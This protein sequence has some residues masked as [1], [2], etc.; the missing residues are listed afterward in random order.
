MACQVQLFG[1]LQVA[2]ANG[3]VT[4]KG[5]KAQGLL[6]FLLL[7]PRVPYPREALAERLWPDA[8][9]A[10]SRRNLSDLLYRLK[11]VLGDAWFLLEPETVALNP[12]L[13]LSVDVWEFEHCIADGSPAALTQAVDLYTGD[14][15]PELYD[16]WL[17]PRR[18]ALR[19]QWLDALAQLGEHAERNQQFEPALT[20]YRRLI[21]ADPLREE[22]WRG[23]MRC[24]ARLGRHATALQHYAQLR[25]VL[26]AELSVPPSA[27]TFM[28]AERL[29]SESLLTQPDDDVDRLTHPPFTGRRQ[30]RAQCLAA[31]EA[32]ISGRGGALLLEGPAGIGKSRLLEEIANGARW[33]GASVVA[34]HSVEYPADAPLAPL[35]AALAQALDGPRAAQVEA[36]LSAETLAALADLVPAWRGCA[37]LPPAAPSEG[38]R[39]LVQALAALFKTLTELAPHVVLL[40]DLHWGAPALW[41]VLDALVAAA[42][43]QRLLFVLAYRRPEIEQTTGWEA[44]QRW[45][46]E[47]ALPAVTL[48]PLTVEE[49]AALLPNQQRTI[50]AEVAAVTG[51]NPFFVTQALIAMHEGATVSDQPVLARAQSLHPSAY[52]ALVAAAV[53][54]AE[55]PFRL[56]AATTEMAPALLAAAAAQL[57]DHY[58]L[59]PVAGGYRFA[60]DLIQ[61]TFYA[62]MEPAQRQELHRRA[63][64]AWLALEPANVRA[65]AFHLDRGGLAA[66]AADSYVQAGKQDL[67]QFAFSE[68]LSAFER[69]LALT[70]ATP[71]MAR[72]EW[73]LAVAQLCDNLGD[74]VRQAAALESVQMIANVLGDIALTVRAQ[75]GLGRLAAV[76]G[77]VEEA[78][79][80]LRQA[81]Q[82]SIQ[83]ADP[84][85][86]FDAHFYAGDLAARRGRPELA[87]TYFEQ[88]QEIARLNGD[89]M[90]EGRA[91]RGLSIA[92]RLRGDLHFALTL[93]EAALA[94]QL[95]A[96][97]RFGASVTHTNVL[98]A[99]YELGAWDRL[100]RLAAEALQLKESLGDRHG[101][102][103]VRHMQGLAAYWLGDFAAAR[104]SLQLAL[105]GFEAV[106]DRRT[107][108]L[109]RNVLGLVAEAGGKTDT[110]VELL[111]A[112]L[113][114]AKAVGAATEAAYAAHD[115]GTLHLQ[116]GDAAAAIPLLEHARAVWQEQGSVLLELKSAAWLGLA[117][118]QQGEV[119]LAEQ[120]AASQLARWREGVPS[121]EA[122]QS[123]LWALQQL[124]TRLGR[125]ADAEEVTRAAF[126]ELQRQASEIQDDA[127]R[128]RFFAGLPLHRAITAA[129]VQLHAAQRRIRVTLAR[130]DAP[131]GRTLLPDEQVAVEWTIQAPE[132]EAISDPTLRRRSILRRLVTEA[133]AQ[134][135]APTDADLAAAL[136]V[137]RRTI[138]RDI[139]ALTRTGVDLP[140]RRRAAAS[141]DNTLSQ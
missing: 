22:G 138:L 41:M 57:M 103:I 134:G 18:V 80:Y 31:V 53:L 65:R 124:L 101:A 90:Q 58:F 94:L 119:Q 125:T 24:L 109:A 85:L 116:C 70:P 135:A 95:A 115:L 66:E 54:G 96:G 122:P 92:A 60:H 51:G 8:S 43:S 113:A 28:L 102:A 105:Q 98:A 93:A 9:P 88:A 38:R 29:R 127:L 75:F 78:E 35:I 19:E 21:A 15:T 68:A 87:A 86:R 25:Q 82:A 133:A 69:A 23:A 27:E 37:S 81:V 56:W 106:Q 26:D 45:E 97:D 40:D 2:T 3:R 114:A 128:Q 33:R 77:R 121:G 5:E 74:R 63:A 48:K 34:G 46:R 7:W 42:T 11:Q 104:Q 126:S 139:E 1:A 16:D 50:A 62:Q 110:A 47:H 71:T 20:A 61:A 67:T 111:A 140:T 52:T 49:T 30:E 10:R 136:R 12:A 84:I 13:A 99:L 131:L 118:Q 72:A 83:I 14:L 73:L 112:A 137:S 132:D 4:I 120:I 89:V 59:Q 117:W 36:I 108:A 55:V 123:W 129:Y 39:R 76:T 64:A 32:A 130:A 141:T 91:L 100:L 6:V 17:I 79:T 44:L 107:A